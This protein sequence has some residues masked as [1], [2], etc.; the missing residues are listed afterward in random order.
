MSLAPQTMAAPLAPECPFTGSRMRPHLSVPFDWRR[1]EDHR[2]WDIWW[3]DQAEYGQV[4]PRPRPVDVAAFYDIDAYYTHA[5]RQRFDPAEEARMVGWRGRVLS[6]LAFR[7][8]NG[9]EP[10]AEWWRSVVPKGARNGLEIGCGNGDRM[11]TYGPFLDLVCGVEPDPRAVSA[12][13]GNGLKVFEGTAEALPVDVTQSTYDLIVFAHVLEHT[14]DPVQ[15]LRNAAALL[16][17][18]GLMSIEVPNNDCMGARMMGPAWR[19]LDAPRH[20]NFF[21]AESL[22]TCAEAAGLKVQAVL[23]RGYVRQFTHDWIVDEA[24]IT[25]TMQGRAMT[26]ADVDRQLRHS[27]KLLARSALAAP[28]H[29]YDSVRVLCTRA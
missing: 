15:S 6:S 3:D 5:E 8:E 13:R 7:F 20:L 26:Q 18:N 23:Y 11:I 17:D 4:H 10:T 16:S 27:A 22:Q 2:S 25:A 9:A 12:A 24:R 29:K 14:I 21:T 1:P 28:G 19:W